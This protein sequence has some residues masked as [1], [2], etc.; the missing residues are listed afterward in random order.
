MFSRVRV[1]K[2]QRSLLRSLWWENE[3][4]WNPIEDCEMCVNIFDGISSPNC[5]NF[6]LKRTSV[7]NEKEFG[8]GAA[9]TLKAKFLC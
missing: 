1:P 2:D 7:D 5:T 8:T 3:D 6:D 9:K 4:I